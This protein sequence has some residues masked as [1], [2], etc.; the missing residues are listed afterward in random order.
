MVAAESG[1]IFEVKCFQFA[2]ENA[3]IE[4]NLIAYFWCRCYVLAYVT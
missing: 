2:K 3:L 4:A 1:K